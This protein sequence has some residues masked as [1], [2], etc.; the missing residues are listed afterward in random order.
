MNVNMKNFTKKFLKTLLML[1]CVFALTACGQDE[2]ISANQQ[3]KQKNAE[4]QAQNVVHM[5]AALVLSQADTSAM[6]DEYNNVE[7]A[8]VF[9]SLY[10]EYTRG[11]TGA[12]EA[13]ISCEGKAVRTA[14]S[15]FES[16]IE[17]MGS[18][19]DFGQPVSTVSDD[20]ITV[21]IPITGENASGSVELIFTNDIYLVMTSCTLNMNQTK[22]ELMAKAAL[23]TLLG[24]GTVFVV[25]ILISLIISV[26]SFIPKLQEKLT[27][28]NAPVQTPAPVPAAAPAVEEAEE[29]LADDTELVAVIAA[30]V[31]A[32]E[33]TA[34]EGFQVRSIRR[35]NAGKWKRA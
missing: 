7:L 13:G 3:L 29:E 8:D 1:T 33:G 4:A 19:K 9:S 21:Q 35:A 34:V 27:K 32:Y 31:A 20:T 6:F 5:T 26:F 15:S 12:S 16:G 28:K 2:T 23:N 24:M 25:L 11:A 17:A 14:F 18:I 10:A 30:A 22:G